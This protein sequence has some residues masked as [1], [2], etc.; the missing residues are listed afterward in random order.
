MSEDVEHLKKHIKFYVAIGAALMVL[1]AVT[2]WV[3]YIP[4][5]TTGHMI[6]GLSIALLKSALVAL[7]FMHLSAEKKLIYRVLVFTGIFFLGLMLL[8]ALAFQ[9]QIGRL[10]HQN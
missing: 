3:A 1:T 2:V 8:T 5:G 10:V 9:D 4:F 7:F 6:V